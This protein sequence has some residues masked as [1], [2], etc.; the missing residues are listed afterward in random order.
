MNNYS[1]TR[2]TATKWRIKVIVDTFMDIPYHVSQ[3]V[4]ASGTTLSGN[5]GLAVR[6]CVKNAFSTMWFQSYCW[7]KYTR[8]GIY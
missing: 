6:V 8:L 5:W 1:W 4:R 7:W 3:L 2:L